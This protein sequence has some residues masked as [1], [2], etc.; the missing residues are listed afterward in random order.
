MWK[1]IRGGL[2]VALVTWGTGAAAFDA[3]EEENNFY[4]MG[5]C[6]VNTRI[7]YAIKQAL[8]ILED[9]SFFDGFR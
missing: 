2:S 9:Y 6:S 5:N 3:S 1:L 4:M 8:V 7:D